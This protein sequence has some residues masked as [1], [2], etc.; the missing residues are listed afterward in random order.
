MHRT[1]N[2]KFTGSTYE[3]VVPYLQYNINQLARMFFT[4]IPVSRFC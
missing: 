1:M 3:S 4:A 2:I